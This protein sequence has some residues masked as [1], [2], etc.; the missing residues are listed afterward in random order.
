[1]RNWFEPLKW[2]LVLVFWL[3]FSQ[4]KSALKCVNVNYSSECHISVCSNNL[5]KCMNF[6]RKCFINFE[7][8]FIGTLLDNKLDLAKTDSSPLSNHP[9]YQNFLLTCQKCINVPSIPRNG[10]V[11]SG[12]FVYY[13][14]FSHLHRSLSLKKEHLIK[15]S[16]LD[17]YVTQPSSEK[18]LIA[19]DGG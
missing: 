2:V 7:N 1:M 18:L 11:V 4:G 5:L 10:F 16:H 12:H 3:F 6:I 13:L 14:Y 17:E 19:A 15:T 8:I 9:G